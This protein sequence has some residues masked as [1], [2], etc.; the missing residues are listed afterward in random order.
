MVLKEIYIWVIYF[1]ADKVVRFVISFLVQGQIEI[2][3]DFMWILG[4][5]W[6]LLAESESH[7]AIKIEKK[8]VLVS[9][10]HAWNLT[11]ILKFI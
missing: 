9:N 2:Y 8:F 1:Q 11:R 5:L 10:K 6:D 3:H 7:L 4:A